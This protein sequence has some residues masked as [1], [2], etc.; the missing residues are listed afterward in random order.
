M[1]IKVSKNISFSPTNKHTQGNSFYLNYD[2]SIDEIKNKLIIKNRTQ[3]YT[4]LIV[5][6]FCIVV[7]NSV[8][9]QICD[10]D[11][12]CENILN[13]KIFE[14]ILHDSDGSHS[15]LLKNYEWYNKYFSNSYRNKINK[16][17]LIQIIID[18]C[19]VQKLKEFL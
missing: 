14:V 6:N 15:E 4:W 10:G 3:T 17:I 11:Q 16:E 19:R 18:I 9:C 12:W 13:C 8:L 7:K 1:A 2:V 5:N